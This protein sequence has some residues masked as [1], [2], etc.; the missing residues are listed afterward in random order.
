MRSIEEPIFNPKHR[1]AGT[2][3]LLGTYNGLKTL[4][5]I[6]RTENEV[7]NLIQESAYAKC[8]GMEDVKQMMVVEMKAEADGG[9]KQGFSRPAVTTDVA[10]YRELFLRKRSDVAKI[11]GV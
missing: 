10:K 11:Y 9:N 4:V 2:P 5:S 8:E 6:K 1:Y 3:D 7:D